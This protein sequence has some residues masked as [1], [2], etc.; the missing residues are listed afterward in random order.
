MAVA[1]YGQLQAINQIAEALSSSE[2]RRLFY[3]CDSSPDA[4]DCMA[5]VKETLTSKVACQDGGT[6]F[7]VE[8]LMQLRRFDILRRVCGIGR[9]E[10]LRSLRNQQVLPEYK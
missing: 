7:L 6:L 5:R 10:V 1:D 3:L 4:E 2:R 9:D 8:L